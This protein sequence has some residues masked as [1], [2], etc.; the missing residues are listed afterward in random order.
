[1]KKKKEMKN[2]VTLSLLERTERKNVVLTEYHQKDRFGV[3]FD[4]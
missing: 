4:Q 3:E 1:M 2:L